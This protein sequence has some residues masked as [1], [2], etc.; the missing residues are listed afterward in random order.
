ML[1]LLLL[2]L[3]GLDEQIVDAWGNV[4]Y[5]KIDDEDD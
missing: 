4:R 2:G 1:G 3:I 5:E